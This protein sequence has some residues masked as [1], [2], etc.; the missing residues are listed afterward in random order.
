MTRPIGRK[1]PQMSHPEKSRSSNTAFHQSIARDDPGS[2]SL[3]SQLHRYNDNLAASSQPRL[4]NSLYRDGI[5]YT[6]PQNQKHVDYQQ[7]QRHYEIEQTNTPLT[8]QSLPRSSPIAIRQAPGDMKTEVYESDVDDDASD[9][10][11]EGDA[12]KLQR[13]YGNKVIQSYIQ[14]SAIL[15]SSTGRKRD[16]SSILNAP[17]LGSLSKSSN[18]V[19]SL[20]PM[21]LAGDSAYLGEPPES[22]VSYGSLRD[23]HERGRFLDGPSSYREPMSGKIRQ[24]DHR[25]RYHGRQP[26]LNIGERLQQSRKQRELRLKEEKKKE[27]ITGIDS[28][29]NGETVGGKRE[30]QSSLSAMMMDASQNAIEG[31]TGVDDRIEDNLFL[32]TERLVPIGNESTM[33]SIHREHHS[34]ISLSPRNMLS[35]SLTAFELLKN[36]N[37]DTSFRGKIADRPD[38][39]TTEG[40]TK[41]EMDCRNETRFQ[42]L[43]R[44]MSDPSPRFQNLSLSGMTSSA[45]FPTLQIDPEQQVNHNLLQQGSQGINTYR[46]ANNAASMPV[47]DQVSSMNG[48]NIHQLPH[49]DHDPNRDGAFGDLDM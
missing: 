47:S 36:A 41:E 29:L 21:S 27:K 24:L 46:S 20:P 30:A 22:I 42:P 37:T 38:A 14:D 11:V 23:S 5:R 35:T 6:M 33:S 15:R 49:S 44:S 3:S 1:K 12:I 43:A 2:S 26:E 31:G 25:L 19:L 40:I 17:Y 8:V 10:D 4:E 16:K 7:R 39:V 18:Q 45:I 28:D 34:S 32:N 9:I 48:G 13:K